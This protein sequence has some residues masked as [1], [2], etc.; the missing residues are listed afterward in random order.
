MFNTEKNGQGIYVISSSSSTLQTHNLNT[1]RKMKKND[2]SNIFIDDED[3][4]TINMIDL[5][6]F[7]C[8]NIAQQLV[9][10]EK[11]PMTMEL[12]L[13]RLDYC[14]DDEEESTAMDDRSLFDND[15]SESCD[16]E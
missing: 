5:F 16:H 11:K 7:N 9:N 4:A 1:S 10:E 15:S 8:S 13:P 3:D 6:L 14:S 12:A 2:K